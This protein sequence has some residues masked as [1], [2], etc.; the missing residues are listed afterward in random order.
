MNCNLKLEMASAQLTCHLAK[1]CFLR[2]CATCVGQL[3]CSYQVIVIIVSTRLEL[4][5]VHGCIVYIN[6][7]C[8]ADR[9]AFQQAGV[10]LSSRHAAAL[11]PP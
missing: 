7:A 10:A 8:A 6:R 5:Y 1:C 3:G 9:Y 2:P 11:R 4:C